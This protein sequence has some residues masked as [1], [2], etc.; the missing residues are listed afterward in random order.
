ME[1]WAEI[2]R[3]VLVEQ[4]SQRQILRETGMH[5]KTLRKILAH[6]E[7]P[8]YRREVSFS[9]PKI[10]PFLDRIR[11]ILEEDRRVPKK[12]RHTA[13]RIFE[14]IQQ[15][16]YTGGYTQVKEAVRE[17][18]QKGQEVFV[19]LIHRPGEA[20]VD[21]GFALVNVA[22][23]LRKLPFFVMT[24]PY[25]GAIFVQVY[26]RMSTEIY[27]DAH[28]RAFEFFDGVAVRITYDNDRTLAA[29]I[30]GAHER[31]L[32]EGFLQL[33]SHYLFDTHFCQV[34][35]PNEKGVV[36]SMVK[37]SRL[38]F[39]VPVPQ[40][41]DLEE[42]NR[43]LLDQCVEDRQRRL[44]GQKATKEVLL[45]E[46]QI[47]FRSLPAA[48]FD[49]CRKASTTVNSL[50]L[51]RFDRNDYSVPVRYAHH[52]VVVKGYVDRVEI[53]C[54][55]ERI[56]T[57]RRLWIQEDVS[58]EPLHYLALLER[59]P[60]AIDHAR[61]LENWDLPDCFAILRRRLED[62]RA[63]DG[64]REFIRVLRLLEKHSLPDLTRAVTKGLRSGVLIRDAIAQ[65]LIPQEE[66]RQTTFRLDGR[67][68]LRQVKV[69]QT[70]VV[71]YSELLVAGG[72]Q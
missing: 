4:V 64:T 42:L 55:Q 62:E 20:Q 63:G 46:D 54:R 37:Y 24:L 59:K 43:R 32:T 10:G 18:K 58:F 25:S 27:W 12:Q 48:P 8:G 30:L 66:W 2:R 34:R 39:M 45:Q 57:H 11:Q 28:R 5:W 51:V 33:K 13:K 16:D 49:A 22:G 56:A 50:S 47:A 23:R 67:E 21:F 3:R 41:H 6:S 61:P 69:T 17:I 15:E 36:E 9:K 19:P 52:P 38:N 29:E 1:Q 70:D 35:R 68:H 60:G 31:K 26:E 7:P 40:V 71:S 53:W 44:R 65:F 72:V 14:R